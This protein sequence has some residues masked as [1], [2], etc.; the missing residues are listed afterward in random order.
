M[1]ETYRLGAPSDA[2]ILEDRAVGIYPNSVYAP[3][4]CI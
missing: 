2:R 1:Q 3:Y 4:T